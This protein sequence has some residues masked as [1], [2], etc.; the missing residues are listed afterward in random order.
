MGARLK[1][2]FAMYI[3]CDMN[4]CVCFTFFPKMLIMKGSLFSP[5][6]YTFSL[7]MYNVTYRVISVVNKR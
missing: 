2:I 3:F 4:E 5:I 7:D 6:K 1:I